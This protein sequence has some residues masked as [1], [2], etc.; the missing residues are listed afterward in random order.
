[1]EIGIDNDIPTYSGG[2]GIL[3]GD[4]LRAA[5]DAGLPVIAVTLLYRK[6]YFRQHLNEAGMQIEDEVV[7]DPSQYLEKLEGPTA[8]VQI[9]G[10]NVT[11]QAWRLL[12][13]GESG[14]KVPILFLD[15]D[16]DGN[17]PED[18]HLTDSLYGGEERYR[19][20]QEIILGMGG[21]RLLKNMGCQPAIF[22]MNEGHSALLALDLL[23]ELL[24]KSNKPSFE[25]A[26]AEVRRRCVF[27][28]HTPVPAGHDRF[29]KSLA[30]QVLGQDFLNL[31]A[32]IPNQEHADLNMSYLGLELS[33][34][35]NGVA[36]RHAEISRQMFPGQ[37]IHAITNGVHSPTWTAP[38]FRLLFDRHF[39]EWRRH[40]HV[41]R[42]AERI[43][44]EEIVDAH[45]Q[46]KIA[47]MQELHAHGY[48]SFHDNCLTLG[49][50]RRST[51]Y[52]RPLLLLHDPERLREI[53]RTHGPLQIVFCGKAHPRDQEGKKLIAAI[54]RLI[55]ALEPEIRIAFLP[56]YDMRLGLL[57]TSGVDVWL[58]TPRA[59]LEASGTSGMK[60][61][62][63]GV[64]NLSVKDG[65]WCEGHI[66]GYTGW[67]I[68]PLDDTTSDEKR[69][70][71]VDVHDSEQLYQLL[72]EKVVPLYYREP[73]N[74]AEMMR[75]AI[76]LAASY[77]NAKRMLDEYRRRAY[78]LE[79]V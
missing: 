42:L 33:G 34:F 27:T 75:H 24:T 13:K 56:G 15:T 9:E 20:A 25:E 77:F 14:H 65:W 38:P 66:D 76:A 17:S 49:F 36:R 22:H 46:C 47:L 79:H 70:A 59:P 54:H 31:F 7:W 63:N 50:A 60:A 41:L 35:V 67:A 72:A 21:R 8:Q 23:N 48:T 30:K 3:A 62:H 43:S 40:S 1:M 39:P 32:R 55:P 78:R 74:W 11:V 45:R 44:L 5:A 28:T 69:H 37:H 73:E 16:V 52:K 61:A 18:R 64:P 51:A 19:L 53:A 68:L 12:I 71:Q 57:M 10:R 2:L 26:I 4:T 58:N 6:G 29:S